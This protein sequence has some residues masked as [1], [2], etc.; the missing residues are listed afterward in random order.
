MTENTKNITRTYL[1][2]INKETQ[3]L[4]KDNQLMSDELTYF[5]EY[6]A[7]LEEDVNLLKAR[8]KK[9]SAENQSL[10][11]EIK[12][13]KFTRKFLTAEDAGCRFAQEL[14]GA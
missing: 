13:M 6:A 5:K 4:K 12:D 1:E 2:K 9:L 10:K 3:Q 8:C 14:G 11:L 7:D